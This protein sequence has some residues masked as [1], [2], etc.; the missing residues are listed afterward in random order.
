MDA[1]SGRGI[2]SADYQPWYLGEPNGSD[3]ENCGI[4]WTTL[5]AWNDEDCEKDICG[6]CQ[7][8]RA[9]VFTLRGALYHDA[10]KQ[11]DGTL[12]NT[13]IA[14]LCKKSR[15]DA[16]Y[17]WTREKSDDFYILRG[18][19][20]ALIRYSDADGLWRIVLYSTNETYASTNATDYPF[21]TRRWLV[22]GDPCFGGGGRGEE[23]AEVEVTL[24]LNACN[25]SEFNCRSGQCVPMEQRCDGVLNCM[26]KSGER[27]LSLNRLCYDVWD[28]CSYY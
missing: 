12:I 15:F 9:P 4:S 25:G 1:N 5:E 27:K 24:N 23:G 13:P 19:R 11:P 28:F 26:D 7:M 16:K 8:D 21:G 10:C 6:F 18:Y 14:G 3:Q 17:S 2:T 20:D 22:R